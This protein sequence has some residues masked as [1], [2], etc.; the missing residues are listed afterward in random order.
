MSAGS[1]V[2]FRGL[3]ASFG[4][5]VAGVLA[6]CLALPAGAQTGPSNTASFKVTS[7][8]QLTITGLADGAG[9]PLAIVPAGLTI[10][11]NAQTG[12][13]TTV[14]ESG[15]G[16]LNFAGVFTASGSGTLGATVNM[17]S[18]VSGQAVPG[19]A[20]EGFETSAGGIQFLNNSGAPVQ[21]TVSFTATT[22]AMGSVTDPVLES[23]SGVFFDLEF[24]QSLG[25]D[26]N[27]P[28]PTQI[29]VDQETRNLGAPPDF[30]TGPLAAPAM[31]TVTIPNGSTCAYNVLVQTGGR[32]AAM[33][34]V[35]FMSPVQLA[36]LA[37]LVLLGGVAVVRRMNGVAIAG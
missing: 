20:A 35:P 18:D 5:L 22:S 11:A 10:V 8:G 32:A 33:A 15:T 16:A 31:R 28:C 17:T 6:G 25:G 34:P 4:A 7:S 9:N 3:R 29:L 23:V 36:I 27:S 19:G 12:I 30:A 26:A 2:V 21:V 37:L 14:E 13:A 24:S 1:Y